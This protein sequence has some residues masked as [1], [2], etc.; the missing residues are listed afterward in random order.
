MSESPDYSMGEIAG[1]L[2]LW[3]AIHGV[4]PA[5]DGTISEKQASE[6][7]AHIVETLCAYLVWGSV[8]PKPADGNVER[9]PARFGFG[10]VPSDGR[11]ARPH[12]CANTD[13]SVICYPDESLNELARGGL[14]GAATTAIS[15]RRASYQA[16]RCLFRA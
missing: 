7:A 11:A 16:R 13:R 14:K 6:I 3:M 9:G 1:Y 8:P 2:S 5:P 10:P 12:Q 15:G 4:D